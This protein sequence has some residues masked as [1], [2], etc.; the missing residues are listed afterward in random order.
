M[1]ESRTVPAPSMLSECAVWE[2]LSGMAGLTGHLPP[3]GLVLEE[4]QTMYAGPNSWDEMVP[5]NLD[6]RR[7]CRM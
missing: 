6:W 4:G 5:G 7:R 1:R 2:G 3:K